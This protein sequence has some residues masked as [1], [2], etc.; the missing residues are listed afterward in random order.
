MQTNFLKF[1]TF[2]CFLSGNISS[3]FIK[4]DYK[5]IRNYYESNNFKTIKSL[6][7][8][9]KPKLYFVSGNLLEI[10]NFG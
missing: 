4:R 1:H 5:L 8:V 2:R 10:N 3:N 7:Q 6:K 9:S